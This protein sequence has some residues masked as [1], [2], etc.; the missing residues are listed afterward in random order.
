[1]SFLYVNSCGYEAERRRRRNDNHDERRDMHLIR[2]LVTLGRT[3]FLY[4]YVALIMESRW[5]TWDTCA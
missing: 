4:Q 2:P 3:Q 1:M 5:A